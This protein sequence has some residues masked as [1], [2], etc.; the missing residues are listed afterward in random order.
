MSHAETFC[1]ANEQYNMNTS[2]MCIQFKTHG[3]LNWT[4]PG[5]TTVMIFALKADE[6]ESCCLATELT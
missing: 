2:K 4:N 5:C 3:K 6:T 1:T